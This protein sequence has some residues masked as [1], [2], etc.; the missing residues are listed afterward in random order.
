MYP[1][2]TLWLE[3]VIN[4]LYGKAGHRRDN[5]QRY[6]QRDS[7]EV[8]RGIGFD[9]ETRDAIRREQRMAEAMYEI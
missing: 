9:Q 7:D 5:P 3:A 1:D 6:W 8:L 2:N 4:D